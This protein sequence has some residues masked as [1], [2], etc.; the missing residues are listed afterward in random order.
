MIG[1]AYDDLYDQYDTEYQLACNVEDNY[2]IIL[3]IVHLHEFLHP[4]HDHQEKTDQIDDDYHY[5]DEEDEDC[6]GVKGVGEGL[7]AGI[8]HWSR[9]IILLIGISYYFNLN[10]H[11]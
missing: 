2:E 5:L 6:S 1:H 9:V 8:V 4:T 10:K 11:E 3:P 7:E